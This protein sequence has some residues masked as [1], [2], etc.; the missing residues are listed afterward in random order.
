MGLKTDLINKAKSFRIGAAAAWLL[1]PR[2]HYNDIRKYLE[3][4][5]PY[6]PTNGQIRWCFWDFF[7]FQLKYKGDLDI[8]YFGAQIYRKSGFVRR[9]SMAHSVRHKWRDAVQDDALQEIFTDKRAFYAAFSDHLGRKWLAVDETTSWEEFCAFLDTCGG[10]VFTKIPKGMGGKGVSLCRPDSEQERRR[11]FEHCR[12]RPMVAEEIL[13]QCE[14]IRSFSEGAVNTLRIITLVDRTGVAHIARA[15]LRMGRSGMEVDN[16][17]SGGLVA[18]VDVDSGVIYSMGRDENG[19]EYIFHPD[20]KRQIVG[21]H[22]P[23]WERY[24]DFARMLAEKYPAMRYVGWDIIQNK[25]GDFC[26]IE[27]NKNA[28]VGGLESGL[29]YGLKPYFD[30][31]LNGDTTFPHHQ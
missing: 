4:H 26:V 1:K 2:K 17:S 21:F 23:D 22:I 18:Q 12:K 8:D 7:F 25:S 19:R 3:R 10:A 9:D 28:G 15:E 27:G 29:L 13:K 11:L 6:P 5:L 31:L 20:S 14:E 24:K 16:F 30:A